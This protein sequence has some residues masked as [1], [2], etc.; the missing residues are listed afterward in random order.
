MTDDERSQIADRLFA[1]IF[2]MREV[3]TPGQAWVLKAVSVAAA[4]AIL[5]TT[6]PLED[7]SEVL[8]VFSAE[9]RR[10]VHDV[11]STA[12]RGGLSLAGTDKVHG[13][14]TES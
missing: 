14:V 2:S 8:D 9:V 4:R 6:G 5:A 7:P 12:I 10:I 3:G 13:A 11:Q 1:T